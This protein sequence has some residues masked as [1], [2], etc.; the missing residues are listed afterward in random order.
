MAIPFKSLRFSRAREQSWG[1]ILYRGILRENED[2]FW[3]EISRSVEGR[4]AQGATAGGLE[5]ISP[6]RNMQFIPY[7]VLRSF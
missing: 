1:I 7:G 4:L 5:D 6:G 2:D 3:P